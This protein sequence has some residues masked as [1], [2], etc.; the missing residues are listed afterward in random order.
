MKVAEQLLPIR[1][2]FIHL[3]IISVQIFEK[4][5][6][7]RRIDRKEMGN[8]THNININKSFTEK[9]RERLNAE[10]NKFKTENQK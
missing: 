3:F 8:F 7:N 4:G 10:N 1:G 9:M 5:R 2:I 6:K